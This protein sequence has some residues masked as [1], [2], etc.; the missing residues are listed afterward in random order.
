MGFFRFTA[1]LLSLPLL[2]GC[3]G[4]SDHGSTSTTTTTNAGAPTTTSAPAKD[5][6][7]SAYRGFWDAYLAAADPMDPGHP[8]L[9]RF[10]TG[11]SLERVRSS[12]TEH[13]KRGEVIRGTVDLAPIV[14]D[15]K[16]TS[17]DLRDCYLDQTHVFDSATGKQVDPPDDATFEIVVTLQLV[18]GGWKVASLDKVADGCEH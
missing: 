1:C 3:G 11:A 8:D 14:E 2:V 4:A 7:L 10:A 6:V 15:I 12:F 5:D 17:A 13:F 16:G 18:D 9:A